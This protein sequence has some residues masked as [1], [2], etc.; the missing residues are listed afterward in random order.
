[1]NSNNQVLIE[2]KIKETEDS[3]TL[4]F[5]PANVLASY[6][7]GQFITLLFDLNGE[8]LRRSYSFSSS[9]DI[10][11][12]PSITVKKIQ[13]GRVSAYLTDQVEVGESISCIQPAGVFTLDK[14]KKNHLIFVG[15]GSGIT[16][17]I[18]MIKS[19]LKNNSFKKVVLIYSNRNEDSVIFK[20]QLEQMQVSYP[21]FSLI[22][23]YSQ[24]HDSGLPKGRLNQSQSKRK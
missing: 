17:L 18:S 13:G 9:P 10:D 22:L 19:A 15:A 20:K 6:K 16:P 8:K 12:K 24:P 23:T 2:E 7:P 14:A 21:K 1:M 4:V 3:V 5:N 11:S